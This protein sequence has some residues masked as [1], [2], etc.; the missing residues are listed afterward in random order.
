[1]IV[2]I[3]KKSTVY[4]FFKVDSQPIIR[5][6][7]MTINNVKANTTP[8]TFIDKKDEYF[9]NHLLIALLSFSTKLRITKH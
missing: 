6:I 9:N 3:A 5:K 4:R 8:L 7:N 2:G 1:M